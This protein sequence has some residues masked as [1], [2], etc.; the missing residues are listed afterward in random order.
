LS[1][2][3]T[4]LIQI[5]AYKDGLALYR[6]AVE[7]FPAAAVLHQ[8]LA[9][10][11][12]NEG[13]HDEAVSASERAL[14]LEP[15]S[16]KLVNDLGWSLFEAGRLEEAE[17]MLKRAVSMDRS[18]ELARENLRVCKAKRPERAADDR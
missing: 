11:A 12:G 13:L 17:T 4:F 14:A 15:D 5:G 10:C 16:Q 9:C 3:G 18:D 2:A 6:T 8:G 1:E 7:K